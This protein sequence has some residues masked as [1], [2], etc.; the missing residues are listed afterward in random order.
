MALSNQKKVTS[1]GV[2]SPP[3][4]SHKGPADLHQTNYFP[5]EEPV[6]GT[7]R[8]GKFVLPKPSFTQPNNGVQTDTGAR[9]T[10]DYDMKTREG[11]LKFEKSTGLGKI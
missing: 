7:S 2:P 3:I 6:R 1:K 8:S 4:P 5:W 10:P 9:L 11:N